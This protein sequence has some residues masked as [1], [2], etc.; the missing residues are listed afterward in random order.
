MKVAILAGGLRSRITET[1]IESKPLARG[2]AVAS[3]G[4]LDDEGEATDVAAS[5]VRRTLFVGLGVALVAV[6][7]QTA[8]HLVNT[9]VLDGRFAALNASE[10]G[11]AFA[12]ASSSALF[13]AGIAALV[14]ALAGS[15]HRR[16]LGVLGGLLVYLSLDDAAGLH[17]RLGN[18]LA[19]LVG[20]S[21][22]GDALF[23]VVYLPLLVILGALAWQVSEAAR[24]SIRAM[25]RLGLA[26]LVLAVGL[27]VVAALVLEAN[28][29]PGVALK[30]LGI[31]SD[32]GAELAGWIVLAAG[33]TALLCAELFDR[34][35]T[36]AHVTSGRLV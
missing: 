9:L 3:A 33:L 11:T 10:E 34:G 2:G 35:R 19:A 23:L 20:E 30:N 32:Q 1:K 36:A 31:A 28:L 22:L 15:H 21:A 5:L 13:A 14:A 16:R 12:W 17:E 24:P 6:A 7:V 8:G 18:R 29:H 4:P 25:L 26:L 27:R